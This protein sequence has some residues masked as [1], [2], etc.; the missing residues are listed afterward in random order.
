VPNESLD[1]FAWSPDGKRVVARLYEEGLV[2]M[3]AHG[4]NVVRITRGDDA[5]PHWS[6][7][8]SRILFTRTTCDEEEVECESNVY[9]VK[10][11]GSDPR[12]LTDDPKAS[13]IGWSPEGTKGVVPRRFGALGDE[14]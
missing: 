10:A 5:D 11:D 3:D 8:G 13:A 12:A 9:V 14:R 1:Q 2:T 7:D 6:P 4:K